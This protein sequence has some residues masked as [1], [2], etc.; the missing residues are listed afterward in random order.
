MPLKDPVGLAHNVHTDSSL[1]D[2]EICR[3][4]K[5][6]LGRVRNATL[7]SYNLRGIAFLAPKISQIAFLAPKNSI[8]DFVLLTHMILFRHGSI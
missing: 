3:V 2:I 4:V 6:T 1:R 7:K 8:V 5:V